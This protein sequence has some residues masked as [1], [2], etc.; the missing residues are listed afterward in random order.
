MITTAPLSCSFISIL[1]S[2]ILIS[3]ETAKTVAS[4]TEASSTATNISAA[5]T[6]TENIGQF[7]GEH[8]LPLLMI[9]NR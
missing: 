2:T 8:R 6:H 1:I 7:K 4:S 9:H 3:D 5:T